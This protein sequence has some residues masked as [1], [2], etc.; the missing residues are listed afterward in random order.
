MTGAEKSLERGVVDIPVGMGGCLKLSDEEM[1]QLRTML[2]KILSDMEMWNNS[3]KPVGA[4][5]IT[6]SAKKAILGWDI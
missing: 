5:A 4:T 6:M 2:N 1:V 3:T